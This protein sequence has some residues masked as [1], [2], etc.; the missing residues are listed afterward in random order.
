MIAFYI[1]IYIK[2]TF[3]LRLRLGLEFL[4]LGFIWIG[5]DYD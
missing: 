2:I 4:S 1:E 5:F 3:L